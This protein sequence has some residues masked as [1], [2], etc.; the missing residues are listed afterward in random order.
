MSSLF[1]RVAAALR[2]PARA[3]GFLLRGE[4]RLNELLKKTARLQ[5]RVEKNAERLQARVEKNAERLTAIQR[6][7]HEWQRR[8]DVRMLQ[9]NLQLGRLA[10]QVQQGHETA[11]ERRR[12]GRP[13][14]LEIEAGDPPRWESVG[15]GA[16]HPDP[17]GK[18]WLCLDVCP[19][20]GHGERTLALEWN[21]LI[22]MA[23]APDQQSDRYDYSVCHACGLVYAA[24]RP[25]GR[26]LRFLLEHFGEVTNK[27]GGS[28]EIT[29]PLLNPYALSERDKENL[30]RMA[31]RG[32]FVSEH[33]GLKKTEYIE[34]ALKDR[35]ENSVHVD[36]LGNLLNLNGARVLEVRSRAGTI[37]ESFRR[38]YK[39]DM[40]VM[41][42]WESQGF[43]LKALYGFDSDGLIDFDHF[44]IP[45]DGVFDLIVCNHILTHSIRPA[46]FLREI[47]RHLKP[48]GHLYLYNEPE[49]RQFLT[50]GKSIIAHL[51]PLHVQT[52]DQPALIR[53]LAANGFEVTFVKERNQN[54]LCL[55][56]APGGDVPWV[57]IAPTKLRARIAAYRRARARAIVKLPEEM[58]KRIAGEWSGAIEQGLGD[59]A[60]D[61][62]DKGQ[63][64]VVVDASA[65]ADT[66]E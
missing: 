35:F 16:R 55:A 29:N 9:Y 12:V 28:A 6:D 25:M 63:L 31:A 34:G 20:C 32:V 15:Q 39:A 52:F 41:P 40:S 18:E 14:P 19:M 56:R 64:K 37:A 47:R 51:N 17:E 49:D 57:P 46:E 5:A 61:F 13:I 3:T 23:K 33:L 1:Q 36:L 26:R 45:F 2:A 24:R 53:G 60:L 43:L 7:V 11:D 59:G 30:R 65:P 48:G 50:E 42:M 21:K 8:L 4:S 54:H 58:R 22:M 38:L 10:Y 44:H 27:A 66:V 62:D